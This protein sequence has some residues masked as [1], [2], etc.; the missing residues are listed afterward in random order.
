[1][2]LRKDLPVVGDGHRR[3][4]YRPPTALLALPLRQLILVTLLG[5]KSIS[6]QTRIPSSQKVPE[7][8]TAFWKLAYAYVL[9]HSDDR[10]IASCIVSVI[11]LRSVSQ[12]PILIFSPP[13]FSRTGDMQEY[14][15]SKGLP[16]VLMNS[17][18]LPTFQNVLCTGTSKSGRRGQDLRLANSIL[19]YQVILE[20]KWSGILYL[21]IDTFVLNSPDSLLAYF[22]RSSVQFAASP[23][24]K[25]C[26]LG[27]PFLHE[28]NS[29]IF[30]VAPNVTLFQSLMN[31]VAMTSGSCITGDQGK[32]FRAIKG[33]IKVHIDVHCLP[34]EYN[35]FQIRTGKKRLLLFDRCMK[36]AR[37]REVK[38]LHWTGNGKPVAYGPD[39]LGEV[40]TISGSLQVQE[41]YQILLNWVNATALDILNF[42]YYLEG[43]ALAST[44]SRHLH[45]FNS[46]VLP[47]VGRIQRLF[48]DE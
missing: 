16:Q 15:K 6:C 44:E 47:E 32:I 37:R 11:S 25:S 13:N 24:R 42:F 23:T 20:E 7:N 40:L 1:M 3:M 19:K 9:T 29:G 27:A 14:F 34:M 48:R 35:C 10:S 2:R 22:A 31:A 33:G 43:S 17:I 21:D 45:V 4:K 5:L 18:Q 26:R 39:T 46:E 8:V 30:Y 36:Q 41:N 12:L 28:F 38:I